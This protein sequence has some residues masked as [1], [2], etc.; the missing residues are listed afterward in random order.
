LI[1]FRYL[2]FD[3]LTATAMA[4]A[5]AAG[6]ATIV[7]QPIEI[8]KCRAQFNRKEYIN[9]R[10]EIRELV[11]DKGYRGIYRGYWPLFWRDVPAWGT[12]FWA[13]ELLKRNCVSD[14]CNASVV[15]ILKMMVCG[16]VAGQLSW[17]VSYPFDVIKCVIQC[18]DGPVPTMA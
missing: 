11:S 5:A 4:G 8:L 16:G 15:H 7:M 1:K 13:Y 10:N 2:G 18:S 3:E 6:S 12:Y 17:I 14:E 9:Y